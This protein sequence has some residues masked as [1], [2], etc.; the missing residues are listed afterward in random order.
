MTSYKYL[1]RVVKFYRNGNFQS[2]ENISKLSSYDS[3]NF[4]FLIRFVLI[5]LFFR[6][7]SYFYQSYIMN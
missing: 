3:F 2:D 7:F 1:A 4:T 5:F 6:S